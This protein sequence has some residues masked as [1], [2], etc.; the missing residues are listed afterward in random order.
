MVKKI[1][2]EEIILYVITI[3]AKDA[4]IEIIPHDQGLCK[5]INIMVCFYYCSTLFKWEVEK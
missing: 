1:Y 3:I 4:L 2:I 5:D